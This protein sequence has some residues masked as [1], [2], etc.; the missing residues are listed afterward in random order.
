MYI[1]IFNKIQTIM[2]LAIYFSILIMGGS[3]MEYWWYI[4]YV[5]K[6]NLILYLG[7]SENDLY[8]QN[9]MSIRG[10]YELR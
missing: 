6:A 3:I 9:C 1:Y 7:V 10:Q 5:Y 4:R 8:Q 2:N